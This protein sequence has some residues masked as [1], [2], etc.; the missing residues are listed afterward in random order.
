MSEAHG[1]A[2][3]ASALTSLAISLPA[4]QFINLVLGNLH[5]SPLA[6]DDYF[7]AAG[8]ATPLSLSSQSRQHPLAVMKS[9]RYYFHHTHPREGIS[10]SNSLPVWAKLCPWPLASL[11][12]A[13]VRLDHG[14]LSPV[15][16]RG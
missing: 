4:F 16:P 7:I 15:F 10:G 8:T 2:H 13:S 9:I 14:F 1:S 11:S 12:V 5:R 6:K 3:V